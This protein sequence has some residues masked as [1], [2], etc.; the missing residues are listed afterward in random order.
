[1]KRMASIHGVNGVPA[2]DTKN[3]FLYRLRIKGIS[4]LT[5]ETI[6][7][8]DMALAA[9]QRT[10]SLLHVLEMSI[11]RMVPT[12]PPSPRVKVWR[13]GIGTLLLE[14]PR[15]TLRQRVVEDTEGLLRL[16]A[17]SLWLLSTQ[18]AQMRTT[19]T[20]LGWRM[21]DRWLVLREP[22]LELTEDRHLTCATKEPMQWTAPIKNPPYK[23]TFHLSA[24]KF[25]ARRLVT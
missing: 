1:M 23:G 6:S 22:Q 13:T 14:A 7:F 9:H 3:A 25:V 8:A 19:L 10:C 18:T 21:E 5:K 17:P 12:L 2:W 15:G 4:G 16:T 20:L 11:P 24:A